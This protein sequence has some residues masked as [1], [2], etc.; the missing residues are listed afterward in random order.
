ME[1]LYRSLEHAGCSLNSLASFL[2]SFSKA[3]S[4]VLPGVAWGYV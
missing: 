1:H 4:A 2:L 3:A